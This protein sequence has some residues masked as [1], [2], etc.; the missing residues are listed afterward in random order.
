MTAVISGNNKVIDSISINL[1]AS[2]LIIRDSITADSNDTFD[3]AS[4]IINE[5]F[6]SDVNDFNGNTSYISILNNSNFTINL[7]GGSGITLKP[8]SIDK[9]L[10]KTIRNYTFVK[11]GISLADIYISG[12][13]TAYGDTGIYLNNSNVIVGNSSNI[14]TPVAVSGDATLSNTGSLTLSNTGVVAGS[15]TNTNLTVDSKGRIVTVSNGGSIDNTISM[16]YT[17]GPTSSINITGSTSYTTIATFN[18]PSFDSS[19]FSYSSGIVTFIK[20]GNYEISYNVQFNSNGN[21]GTQVGNFQSRVLLNNITEI[22]GSVTQCNMPRLA[23]TNNRAFNSKTLSLSASA[24][25]NV[26]LQWAELIT[27]TVA[28]VSANECT[29]VVLKVSTDGSF[30]A[31]GPTSSINITG[32]T[33]Y[34]TITTFNSPTYGGSYFSYSSGVV[35]IIKPGNYEI[36]YNVQFNSNGNSGTQTGNF[37]T[38]IL[39]NNTTEIPGS[40]TQCNM[41]RLAGTNNR[42]FNSKKITVNVNANDTIQLQWAELVTNTVA[43]VSAD[44]CTLFIT[45]LS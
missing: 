28:Q 3:T 10:P 44:E 7:S 2:G 37:Q 20:P 36:S 4:N 21:T 9:I 16:F 6:G 26:R 30:F 24:N 5:C 1:S 27:N 38:R 42:A 11:T 40:V 18:T 23:G 8:S 25:D 35:T 12:S 14:G 45:K 15:Y 32:S 29:F 13:G 39:L 41:P 43:Q 31:Y 34:T 19:F 33:S 22:P 17:Y